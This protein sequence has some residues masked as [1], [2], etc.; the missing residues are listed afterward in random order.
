LRVD[1]GIK[2]RVGLGFGLREKTVLDQRKVG[3]KKELSEV[4]RIGNGRSDNESQELVGEEV[5]YFD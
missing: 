1:V 4:C 3:L 2:G 5:Q